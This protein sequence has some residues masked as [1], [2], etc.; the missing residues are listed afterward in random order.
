MERSFLDH[1]IERLLRAAYPIVAA[2]QGVTAGAEIVLAL[3][4]DVVLWPMMRA[5]C[6]PLSVWGLVPDSGITHLLAE[7]IGASRARAALML[8]DRIDARTAK[9]WGLAHEVMSRC[10]C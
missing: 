1:V 10:R 4:A 5:F 7:R 3:T 2:L 6:L 8:G 9:E